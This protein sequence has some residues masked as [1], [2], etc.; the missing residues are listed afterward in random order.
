MMS[1]SL[2]SCPKGRPMHIDLM[3]VTQ[4]GQRSYSFMSQTVGLFADLDLGTEWMRCLG[5][6]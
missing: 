1:M 5:A 6:Q 3:S 4:N 2:N